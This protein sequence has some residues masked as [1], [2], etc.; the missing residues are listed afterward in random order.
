MIR[1]I[2]NKRLGKTR[3][4]AAEPGVAI[5]THVVYNAAVIAGGHWMATHP[6]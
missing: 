5:V 4:D 6:A 2:M 1:L 3:D